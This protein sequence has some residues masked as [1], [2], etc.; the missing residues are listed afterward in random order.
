MLK[1]ALYMLLAFPV[2]S[3]M[4]YG[5]AAGSE[6]DLKDVFNAYN[7]YAKAGDVDKMLALRASEVEK[8]IRS[9]IKGKQDRADFVLMGRAQIPD[10]YEVQHVKWAKDGMSAE[11][12]SV[13][14][15][16]PMKEIQRSEKAVAEVMVSFKKENGKWK[17]DNILA[18]GDPSQIKRPKDL[19]YNKQDADTDVTSASVAG[20]IV[21]LEFK[22]DHTLVI[23]RVMDE[24]I[25]VFLPPKATLEKAGMNFDDLAPWKMREFTGYPHKKDKLKFFATGDNAME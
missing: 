16:P 11:L 14:H 9:Q 1:I 8:E 23:V 4:A 3:T 7:G 10:T 24:E 22:T 17:M 20:R 15:L 13:W 2:L 19:V 5:A 25:A 18:L 12:Y 6:K 21:K